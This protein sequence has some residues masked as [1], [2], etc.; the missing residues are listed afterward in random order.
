V[1]GRDAFDPRLLVSLW[2][3]ATSEGVS[4]AREIR[5]LCEYHPAYQWLT[6]M[7]PVNHHTLSDFRVK[8]R[9]ALDRLFVDIL[10]V[11]SAE[12]LV[13][14]ERVMH[15]GTKVKACAGADSFRREERLKAHLAMAQEQ[16]AAMGDPRSA[17]EV[18]PRVAAAQAR[19]ARD[20][21]QR[22]AL[23]L[24]EL[25]KIRV[26]KDGE[27]AKQE[28]RASQT[29]PEARMMK[30]GNGGYAPS[31]N[32]QISTEAKAGAIVGMG[33]SQA[34]S[35]YGELSSAV[36]RV[37]ENL[38]KPG[39]VVADGGFTSRSNIVA[40]AERGV[41]FIG[42][43]QDPTGARER[44][45][46]DSA[47]GPEAFVYDPAS[48]A[49]RCPAGQILSYKS[50]RE[51]PGRSEFC[52][53]A[54]ALDCQACPFKARCCPENGSKGRGI[55]RGVEHPAVI[56]YREKMERE[57]AK[58][59]YKQRGGIAEFPNAWIKEKL[60]LRQ[61]RCRGLAKVGMEA[62]WSGLTYN[63][64]LWIRLRWRPQWQ[65]VAVLG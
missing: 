55:I 24:L 1:A 56:A 6:G 22:L 13:S 12:G 47:F 35:D 26:A 14:L 43:L 45:G 8:H 32:V 4:S 60:G 49:Y 17:A 52:Y 7:Q 30:Q 38:D 61:F 63:I 57:E 21:E 58:A 48:D 40:M 20:K 36:D 23:A 9:E 64:Q 27:Q 25:E 46:I 11:L 16:V 3:Y 39:Q 33:T 59:I 65:A 53:S 37:E 44:R 42:S 62:L 28:A 34:A 10:G 19:A 5:R 41:D 31:Y 29:D 51:N 15:D 54:R 18:S 2:V 50:K